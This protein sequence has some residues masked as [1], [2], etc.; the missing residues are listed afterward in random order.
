MPREEAERF[1][2]E[3]G[4][5]FFET[6]AKDRI[7]VDQAFLAVVERTLELIQSKHINVYQEVLIGVLLE[8]RSENRG[9]EVFR[10]T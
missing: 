4:L 10:N 3:N 2:A 7:N 1:A 6:S 5:K 9:Q 8:F